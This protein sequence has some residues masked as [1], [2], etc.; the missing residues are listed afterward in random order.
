MKIFSLLGK[1]TYAEVLL[2]E[3]IG[4]NKQEYAIKTYDKTAVYNYK[5]SESLIVFILF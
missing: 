4:E 1:G 2:A 3:K 5:L